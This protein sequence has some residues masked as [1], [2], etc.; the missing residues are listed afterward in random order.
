[1]LLLV[2]WYLILGIAFGF[3]TTYMTLK[4]FGNWEALC[5]DFN[6]K[7]AQDDI[8]ALSPKVAM[9]LIPF[10]YM[11]VFSIMW[12]PFLVYVGSQKK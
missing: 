8:P 4:K 11:A 2:Y 1:M 3:F 10:M 6:T 7:V 12:M 9:F 5:D